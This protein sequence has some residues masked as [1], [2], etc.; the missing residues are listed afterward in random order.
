MPSRALGERA[1]AMVREAAGDCLDIKG[2]GSN[3]Q[4]LLIYVVIAVFGLD[5]IGESIYDISNKYTVGEK[6]FNLCLAQFMNQKC[7]VSALSPKCLESI[8]CMKGLD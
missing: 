4:L 1:K 3:W 5:V 8:R 2:K 7:E 6:E